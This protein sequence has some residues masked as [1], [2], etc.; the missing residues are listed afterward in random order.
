MSELHAPD[1]ASRGATNHSCDS[2]EGL[3]IAEE[4]LLQETQQDRIIHEEVLEPGSLLWR[5]RRGLATWSTV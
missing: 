2:G 1:V 5:E 3:A 4:R